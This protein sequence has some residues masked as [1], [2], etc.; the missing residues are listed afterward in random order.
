MRSW[1]LIIHQQKVH[2]SVVGKLKNTYYVIVIISL[3]IAMFVAIYPMSDRYSELRP[4]LL[5]LLVIYWVTHAPQNF[6]VLFAWSVGL[7]Q[8]VIEGVAWGAHAMALSIV[9]YICLVAYQRIKN[10]SVWHQSIWVFIFVGFH[11]VTVNWVQGLAGYDATPKELILSA[12]VSAL[13]WP[14]LFVSLMRIRLIY[15]LG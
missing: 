14:V 1:C 3:C 6:G 13:F 15:R 8:D 4:E 12:M 11:Q 2:R 10:Y 7:A 9:A 5:C